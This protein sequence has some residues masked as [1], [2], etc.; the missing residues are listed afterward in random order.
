MKSSSTSKKIK[1]F[2]HPSKD[3]FNPSLKIEESPFSK[4][5]Q[6]GVNDPLLGG[7]HPLIALAHIDPWFPV[8]NVL[9]LQSGCAYLCRYCPVNWRDEKKIIFNTL[10]KKTSDVT[11]FAFLN[12][13]KDKQVIGLGAGYTDPFP[14]PEILSTTFGK[15]YQKGI[16][17]LLPKLL[18]EGH[19]LFVMTKNP[20]ALF[21]LLEKTI[22]PSL[23]ENVTALCSLAFENG[24]DSAFKIFEPN[25]PTTEQRWSALEK[26]EEMGATTGIAYMPIMQD[27][28]DD[29]STI[30]KVLQQAKQTKIK[31]CI[32]GA[33]DD[34]GTQ[35]LIDKKMLL[36]ETP[37][38]RKKIEQ[39][40]IKTLCELKILPLPPYHVYGDFLSPRDQAIVYLR[41]LFLY[42][43]W[44]DKSK[45][46]LLTTARILEKT[47]KRDFH[48]FFFKRTEIDEKMQTSSKKSPINS[49]GARVEHLL[50]TLIIRKKTTHLSRWSKYFK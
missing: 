7:D 29:E 10:L 35:H 12:H 1:S 37:L 30:Y 32:F 25:L 33:L 24:D 34:K 15:N 5:H 27:I 22:K 36:A 21:E 38:K 11:S 44:L 9:D 20:Q 43:S 42:Q 4:D 28:N 8:R 45:P 50:K 41:Q 19:H 46:G 31:F 16:E 48:D 3:V 47:D 39:F 40:F 2:A 13:L 49:I 18:L 17:A 14:P 26:L 6:S 23:F